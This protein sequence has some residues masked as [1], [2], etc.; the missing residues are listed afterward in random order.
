MK[1]SS[2]LKWDR[3]RPYYLKIGLICALAFVLMAF[4]YTSDVVEY[5]DEYIV[6]DGPIFIEPTPPITTHEKK[7]LPPP[8][9]ETEILTDELEEFDEPDYIEED[10]VEETESKEEVD[11]VDE[12][13]LPT[14]PKKSPP[15]P[16]LAPIDDEPE[17]EEPV[18]FADRMPVYGDCSDAVDEESRRACSQKAMLAF[19]YKHLDY[20]SIA[21][22]NRIE[23]MVVV[24]FII[25]KDGAVDKV[26][27]VKDIGGGCG[28]EVVDVI[29]KLESFSPGRQGGRLVDVIY[30]VPVRFKLK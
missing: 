18:L 26:E 14:P 23:G 9:P 7:K 28:R 17:E 10:P 5:D 11:L 6:D 12:P 24:S 30:R 2:K 25:R 20:P 1:R 15:V 8:P 16:I 19:I 21:R 3:H 22:S 13:Y 29:K 27:I 4:N